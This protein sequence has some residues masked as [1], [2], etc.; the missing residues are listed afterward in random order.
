MSDQ[1]LRDYMGQQLISILAVTIVLNLIIFTYATIKSA[2]LSFRIRKAEK[3]KK[4]ALKLKEEA[5]KIKKEAQKVKEEAEKVKQLKALV[6][7]QKVV[8]AAEA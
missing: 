1:K 2:I 3:W 7:K 5:E 8:E 4:E 6:D